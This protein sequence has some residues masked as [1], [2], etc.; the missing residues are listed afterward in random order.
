MFNDLTTPRPEY[1]CPGLKPG[2]K[3]RR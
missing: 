3:E 2:D 1:D